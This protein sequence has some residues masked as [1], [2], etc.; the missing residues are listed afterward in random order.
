MK[1]LASFID[2]A[3][4]LEAHAAAKEMHFQWHTYICRVQCDASL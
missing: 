1:C 3:V 4:D 2:L